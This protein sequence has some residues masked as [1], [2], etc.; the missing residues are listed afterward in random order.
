MMLQWGLYSPKSGMNAPFEFFM[1]MK[2]KNQRRYLFSSQ[3]AELLYLNLISDSRAH[4]EHSIIIQPHFP[5]STF[6][7]LQV[8]RRRPIYTMQRRHV[9]KDKLDYM[10]AATGQMNTRLQ[11]ERLGN[12]E[13]RRLGSEN[14][15]RRR[16][17]WTDE[18]TQRDWEHWGQTHEGGRDNWTQV[19]HIR[20][21]GVR[22]SQEWEDKQRREVKE[23]RDTQGEKLQ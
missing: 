3:T 20:A 7:L 16:E 4:C 1:N 14:T 22:Q 15:R 6:K 8:A 12:S 19:K 2:N 18:L 10:K 5:V 11:K 23:Q 9:N 21:G 17:S 13:D